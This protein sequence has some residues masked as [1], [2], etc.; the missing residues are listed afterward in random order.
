MTY[1][2]E[3]R[4]P[5]GSLFYGRV[6][7]ILFDSGFLA[8]D[9]VEAGFESLESGVL[10]FVENEATVDRVN[11]VETVGE[12]DLAEAGVLV[13]E[14]VEVHVGSLDTVVDN[15]C[16][17]VAREYIFTVFGGSGV[18]YEG[19]CCTFFGSLGVR[20]GEG[21]VVEIFGIAEVYE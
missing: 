21:T 10:C 16:A 13:K 9:D 19:Y 11:G 7:G 20:F 12:L 4:L 6:G 5:G 15:E 1:L 18:E 14:E 8:V 2:H 3:K 17:V